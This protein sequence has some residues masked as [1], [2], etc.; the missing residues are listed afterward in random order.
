MCFRIVILYN[1]GKKVRLLPKLYL[2]LQRNQSTSEDVYS[3]TNNGVCG[4]A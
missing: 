3:K 1:F 2:F 4:M